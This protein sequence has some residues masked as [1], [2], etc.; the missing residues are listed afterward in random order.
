MAIFNRYLSHYQRV[1]ILVAIA[2]MERSFLWQSNPAPRNHIFTHFAYSGMFHYEHSSRTPGRAL[3][4]CI[5][6][7]VLGLS[8]VPG[9]H[10]LR[11]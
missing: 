1:A 6:G 5:L 3:E 10:S 9:F 11:A 8:Q 4:Q 2:I 7:A